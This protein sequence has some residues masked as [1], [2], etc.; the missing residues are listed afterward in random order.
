[1]T[2]NP[3][4]KQ[5]SPNKRS[6][7]MNKKRLSVLLGLSLLVAGI[8]Y[9]QAPF[10]GNDEGRPPAKQ[11]RKTLDLA[12]SIYREMTFTE[13]EGVCAIGFTITTVNQSYGNLD[14]AISS[15]DYLA[16]RDRVHYRSE[17]VAFFQDR[18]VALAVVPER[19]TVFVARSSMEAIRKKQADL[20]A[21][22]QD[23][24]FDNCTVISDREVSEDRSNRDLL[25]TAGDEI[26]SRFKIDRVALKVDTEARLIREIRA[27][28][29]PGSDL[30]SMTVRYERVEW[31][32]ST[33]EFGRPILAMVF[34]E[35]GALLP[36]YRGYTVIDRRSEQ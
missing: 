1:M 23:S 31:Q 25:L 27:D 6:A 15:V 4:K 8:L 30:Q 24:L 17:Q 36:D 28:F 19:R 3:L 18:D 13:R 2:K 10:G 9:A 32:E 35:S 21:H 34:A 16:S 11:N 5:T 22:L 12:R 33:P 26:R 14:T 29:L 20:F 7:I